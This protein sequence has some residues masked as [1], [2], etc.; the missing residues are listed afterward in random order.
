LTPQRYLVCDRKKGKKIS[1]QVC[2]NSCK[3]SD[4]CGAFGRL[5]NIIETI[6][7]TRGREL[8]EKVMALKTEIETRWFELG[9]VLQE[10]FEG[11]HYVDLGYSTWRAFCET[12]LGPLELKPRAIDYI[13][14]TRQ[15][16]DEVGIGVEVAG[17]IGWSRLKEL[18]PVVTEENKAHWLDVAKGETVQSLNAKV[19]VARGLKTQEEA[20]LQPNKKFFALFQGQQ[21]IV[22]L[23]L[24]IASRLSASEKEGYL[25]ADVICASFLAEYPPGTEVKP[26]HCFTPSSKQCIYISGPYTL[27]NPQRNVANAIKVADKVLEMGLIPFIPHLSYYWDEISP[28]DWKVWIDMDKAWLLA[29]GAVLRMPGE[30]KGADLE[31]EWA[32]KHG[33]PVYTSFK[34]LEKQK[35]EK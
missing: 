23:A 25:L 22:E 4:K 16:C 30:S 10:I 31:V 32:K 5:G 34:E 8:Y 19:A 24:E 11:R 6:E 7:T 20:N 29:C 21:E 26:K 17:Q 35:S 3:V 13:R 28:K 27:P 1:V 15:K 14:T 18:V 2:K 12:A 9:R 33:I